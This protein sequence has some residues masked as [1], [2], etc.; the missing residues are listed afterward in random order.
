[1]LF[2]NRTVPILNDFEA[3]IFPSTNNENSVLPPPTS[4]Y[5]NVFSVSINR[6]KSEDAIMAASFLPSI[7]SISISALFLI[8]ST[9][10]FP[11]YASR[12]AEVAQA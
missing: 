2:N 5:K 12:N 8:I 10:S 7:M 1:M 11:L 9:T 6:V 4:T 3:I